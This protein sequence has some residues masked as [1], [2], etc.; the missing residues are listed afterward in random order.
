MYGGWTSHYYSIDL[1]NELTPI[2][3][4]PDYLKANTEGVVQSLKNVD[5][6]AVWIMQGWLFVDNP[7]IWNESTIEGLL[8]GAQQDEMIILDLSSEA[9]PAWN[10]TNSFYGKNWVWNTLMDYGGNA[11]M[12]GSVSHY[13][14]EVIR[15]KENSSSLIGVGLTPEGFN[16]NELVYEM[17][18][19]APWQTTAIDPLTW[20]RVF[21]T[22][23]Y[24]LG[25]PGMANGTDFIMEAWTAILP[26]AY[27]NTDFSIQSVP[28]SIIELVPA[29]EGLVNRTGRHGTKL[30]Y[31]NL[32][33]VT[34]CNNL[35]AAAFNAPSMINIPEY[36]YDMVVCTRQVLLNVAEEIYEQVSLTSPWPC[37]DEFADISQMLTEWQK[38]TNATGMSEL[39]D[40]LLDILDDNDRVMAV[41]HNMLL[42]TWIGNARKWSDDPATQ[43][44]YEYQARNQITAWGPAPNSSATWELDRY[45]TKQWAGLIG[46]FY[47][48]S[49]AILVDYLKTTPPSSY[50]QTLINQ[51]VRAYELDWGN[52]KWGSVANETWST[53]SEDLLSLIAMIRPKWAA[54]LGQ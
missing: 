48:D 3:L 16:N 19:D 14:D 23:R 46:G 10:S 25:L 6:E 33:L 12:Y 21:V 32:D 39:G 18:L 4:S 37:L 47:H 31:A 28:K 13:C 41:N 9:L 30:P 20:T 22:R 5:P 52:Q 15:A 29:T 42:S 8:S 34:S 7:S 50:N 27:N 53:S 1:F 17:A 35:L 40:Q 44:F 49:W 45:A 54:W 26:V 11:G 43:D 51:Q 38:T 24:G 2:S 36:Q